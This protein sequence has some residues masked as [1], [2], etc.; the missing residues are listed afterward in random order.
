MILLVGSVVVKE[1][2]MAEVLTLSREHVARSREEPGC[3]SHAVHLDGEKPNRLVF[4][5]EWQDR[6]SLQEHFRVPAS[7][8]FGMA[9]TSLATEPPQLTVYDASIVSL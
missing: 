3:L 7:R 9:L 6:A 1:G 5:E 4:V 2:A 8:A